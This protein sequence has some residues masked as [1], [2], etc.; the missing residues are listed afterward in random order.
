MNVD[1]VAAASLRICIP[2]EHRQL[3]GMYTFLE[4]WRKWLDQN[5]IHHTADPTAEYNVLFVNSFMVPYGLIAAAK[6]ARPELLIVQR[7]DGAA[8]DYGR[9]DD[10]DD[11]QARVNMLADLTIY[12]SKYSKYSTTQKIKVIQ[13]DG[14]II[15]NPVDIEA[16]YADSARSFHADR[17]KICNASHSENLRKGTWLIGEIARANPDLDFVLCGNYPPL[18]DLPNISLRGRL[19]RADLARTMRSCDVFLHL[20]ENDPC[21]N[22]VLE[23]LASGLPVLYRDS[24]GTPELV[25][26]SGR[27]VTLDSFRSELEKIFRDHKDLS[28]AARERAV[29]CFAPDRIFPSYLDAITRAE[30]RLAPSGGDYLRAAMNGYPVLAYRPRSLYWRIKRSIRGL[31]ALS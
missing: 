7:V 26:E 19:D 4:N 30:R 10:A 9:L 13:Q 15:Y 18:P 17:P 25:G 27:P 5:N 3:G 28:E 21:P 11:R 24:G 20:A 16:F 29:R 8:R 31:R 23:A 22:V 6:R 2:I 12:Q 14:P 1:N